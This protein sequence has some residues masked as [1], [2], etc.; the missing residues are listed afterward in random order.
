MEH[1]LKMT[2]TD[3]LNYHL[4][5]FFITFSLVLKLFFHNMALLIFL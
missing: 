5:F 1:G 3:K 4:I 2:A